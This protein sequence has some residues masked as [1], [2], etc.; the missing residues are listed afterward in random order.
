MHLCLLVTNTAVSACKIALNS[1]KPISF[2][3]V[4][5]ASQKKMKKKKEHKLIHNSVNM[6]LNK[7]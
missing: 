2:Y 5:L 3:E 1:F 4:Q 6:R 7:Q